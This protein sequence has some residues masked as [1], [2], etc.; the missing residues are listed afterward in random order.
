MSSLYLSVCEFRRGGTLDVLWDQ[1]CCI[2]CFV[3]SSTAIRC[4]CDLFNFIQT[5]QVTF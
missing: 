5:A 1:A 4:V 2:F 3:I